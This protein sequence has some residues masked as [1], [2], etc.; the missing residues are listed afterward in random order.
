MNINIPHI[1]NS[2]IIYKSKLTEA[3]RSPD[4]YISPSATARNNE[5]EI[6]VHNDHIRTHWHSRGAR[7]V[8]C[9]VLRRTAQMDIQKLRIITFFGLNNYLLIGMHSVIPY[10]VKITALKKFLCSNIIKEFHCCYLM[11]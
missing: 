11:R 1:I 4:E 3:R 7:R 8:Q 2:C 5:F 6:V 9:I 10:E